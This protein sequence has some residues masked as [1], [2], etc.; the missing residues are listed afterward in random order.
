MKKLKNTGSAQLWNRPSPTHPPRLP[1]PA[2]F[3][4]LCLSLS[5]SLCFSPSP[6]VSPWHVTF[7][8]SAC[9]SDYFA[10]CA[11][12]FLIWFWLFTSSYTD[13]QSNGLDGAIW[14]LGPW[15][16]KS[17]YR[18]INLRCKNF[19]QLLFPKRDFHSRSKLIKEVRKILSILLFLVYKSL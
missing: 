17:L 11:G 14:D 1:V 4:P 19:F 13:G 18:I 16:V 6:P 5:L 10:H 3:L 15:Q 2:L 7:C 8:L 12:Q 9:Q